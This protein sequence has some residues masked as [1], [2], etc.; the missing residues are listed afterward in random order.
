[1]RMKVVTPTSLGILQLKVR[2]NMGIL[3]FLDGEVLVLE[4][5]L[6]VALRYPLLRHPEALDRLEL[7]E[8]LEMLPEKL[9]VV[10]GETMEELEATFESSTASPGLPSTDAGFWRRRS[11]ILA[12]DKGLKKLC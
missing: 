12:K 1:M 7:G 4:T 9:M 8:Y 3:L 2:L 5:P 10:L 11:P 6:G